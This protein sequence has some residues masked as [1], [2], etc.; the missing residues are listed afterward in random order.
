MPW[1]QSERSNTV[2]TT[3]RSA[4]VSLELASNPTIVRTR[5]AKALEVRNSI[6]Q[7]AGDCLSRHAGN[8]WNCGTDDL[9]CL[10]S[11]YSFDGFTLGELAYTCLQLQCE[12]QTVEQKKVHLYNICSEESEAVKATHSTLTLPATATIFASPPSASRRETGPTTVASPSQP[13]PTLQTSATPSHSNSIPIANTESNSDSLLS[14]SE[15]ASSTPVPAVAADNNSSKN[16]TSAQAA[17][18]SVAAISVL[19]L[20]IGAIILCCCIR[21]RRRDKQAGPRHSYDFV[22]ASPPRLPSLNYFYHG[23][24]DSH[25]MGPRELPGTRTES[26]MEH[27]KT[28][29]PL[30]GMIHKET[31]PSD[32]RDKTNTRSGGSMESHRSDGSMRTLS[33]LLPEKP[34]TIPRKPLPASKES[35]RPPSNFTAA[36]VF[37]EDRSPKFSSP[38]LGRFPMPPALAHT[39][40]ERRSQSRPEYANNWTQSPDAAL[41][42]SLS[43][44]IPPSYN[45]RAK[46]A[47]PRPFPPPP[48]P[49]NS[50]SATGRPVSNSSRSRSMHSSQPRNSSNSYL[51]NYYT[52]AESRTPTTASGTPIEEEPQNR[53][54]APP[55]L[56]VTKPTF[57]PKAFR[58][59]AAS[60]TSFESTDPDEPTPPEE[61]DKHLSPVEESPIAALRYPKV[62]R[63]S[64]QAVP[65]SP[66]PTL[67]ARQSPFQ[68]HELVQRGNAT[69]SP[70]WQREQR[71]L[72][73]MI[74]PERQK[75]STTPSLSGSTLAVKQKGSRT[76]RDLER[77]LFVAHALDQSHKQQTQKAAGFY[78]IPSAKPSPLKTSSS[79][80]TTNNTKPRPRPQ[81]SPLKGYGTTRRS[82]PTNNDNI[83]D[84]IPNPMHSDPTSK[85]AQTPSTSTIHHPQPSPLW[86][87]KLTPSRRGEDLWLS[88][89]VASPGL[90]SPGF[91]TGLGGVGRGGGG[92]GDVGV[93]GGSGR[94]FPRGRGREHSRVP[95]SGVGFDG[96]GFAR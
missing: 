18:I 52:S 47:P 27:R 30:P 29:W 22:D 74:T 83:N 16:L 32:P 20:A 82:P 88:V 21:R 23:N 48:I 36:T 72:N 81:E 61:S 4:F 1:W 55:S 65:R 38:V 75:T 17:G 46:M 66:I 53:R 70:Q 41:P 50:P 63:S 26:T 64:N 54:P 19:L 87:P 13:T 86:E 95:G 85:P 44:K 67:S 45:N 79:D 57:Q 25:S 33:Q 31:A 43:I 37:E 11:K 60:D 8:G 2:Q 34:T 78:P 14:A 89:G 69:P 92:D 15:T 77:Q 94:G 39:A 59:S 84:P 76:A 93:S 80:T 73:P 40:P 58:S 35:P 49:E 71:S 6:P 9:S 51:P 42:P 90:G 7:C 28:A 68:S 91:G 62:P 10:C 5:Q 3:Q 56:T 24:R 96:V 12:S